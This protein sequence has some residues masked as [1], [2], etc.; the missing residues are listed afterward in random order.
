MSAFTTQ[1]MGTPPLGRP[2]RAT[3]HRMGPRAQLRA[4]RLGRRLVQ[5]AL[6]L[7]LYGVSLAMLIRSSL[8]N[9]PWDVLHQGMARHLPVTIG[10]AVIL[11][12]V[13]VLLAWI[14]LRE[15]PGIGTV[16]N[17]LLV[18]LSA[19]AALAVIRTPQAPA[20]QVGLLL[21]GIWLCALATALYLGA[22]FGAGPRDGLMT[23]LHRVTGLSLRLVRTALEIAVV[24]LG[25][26]LGGTLGVGTVLFALAIGPLAQSMLPWAVVDL[27]VPEP[28][29]GQSAGLRER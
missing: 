11:A 26:L 25:F 6:G 29:S 1:P 23:G 15:V 9:A 10:Q 22:Q 16:A 3:L 8:G 21:G 2:R 13:V 7:V 28:R 24:V 4:G 5:L 19:D 27:D 18:G 20:A 14:P 12:S 17:A